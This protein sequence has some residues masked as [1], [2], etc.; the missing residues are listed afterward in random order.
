MTASNEVPNPDEEE[1]DVF[2]GNSFFGQLNWSDIL[3][4]HLMPY[5]TIED[6]FRSIQLIFNLFTSYAN[7][8][9]YNLQEMNSALFDK[10]FFV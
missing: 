3:F 8:K 4:P 1:E 2:D 6:C 5:L 7:S 9:L 10:N